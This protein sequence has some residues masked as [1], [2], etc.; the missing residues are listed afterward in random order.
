MSEQAAAP[1]GGTTDPIATGGA[2]ALASAARAGRQRV[3]LLVGSMA[4]FMIGL[5]ATVVTTA[6]PTIHADLHASVST[7]RC[8]SPGADVALAV[9]AAISA[10]L[11]A[12]P[13]HQLGLA[14]G[15]GSTFQNVGGVFGIATATAVFASAGGYLT[16]TDFVDGLRPALL[17]LAGL[18]ALGA[19]ASLG[20]PATATRTAHTPAGASQ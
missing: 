12:L 17:A 11:R 6:L 1:A 3:T 18:A 5:D 8:C 9:P 16:P 15:I 7:P 19:L 20:T 2:P 14:S 13:G 4:G 10:S